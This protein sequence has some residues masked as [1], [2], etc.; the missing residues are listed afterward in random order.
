MSSPRHGGAATRRPKKRR[1]HADR[2]RLAGA[3]RTEKAEDLP[4]RHVQVDAVDGADVGSKV[5]D[6]AFSESGRHAPL[7]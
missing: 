2:G 4:W 7:L 5:L 1:E 6:Q 3:V